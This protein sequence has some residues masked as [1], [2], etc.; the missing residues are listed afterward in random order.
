MKLIK[1]PK[2]EFTIREL[3]KANPQYLVTDVRLRLAEAIA[4]GEVE[5]ITMRDINGHVHE[6]FA[7]RETPR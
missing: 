7:Y 2:G 4:N 1:F 5:V 3:E 6:S